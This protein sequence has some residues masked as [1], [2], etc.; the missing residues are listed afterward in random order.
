MGFT[1]TSKRFPAPS[2][3]T[4]WGQKPPRRRF[5]A[6]KVTDNPAA[7]DAVAEVEAAPGVAVVVTLVAYGL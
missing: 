3:I 5:V 1:V 4:E 7:D 2:S 6:R